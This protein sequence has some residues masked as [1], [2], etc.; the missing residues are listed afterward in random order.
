MQMSW[1][2]G[3]PVVFEQHTL[4][5]CVK[6]IHFESKELIHEDLIILVSCG[7]LVPREGLS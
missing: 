1:L 7:I 6:Q 4:F 3:S 5:P 2:L